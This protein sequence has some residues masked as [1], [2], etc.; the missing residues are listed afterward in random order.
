M[1][2]EYSTEVSREVSVSPDEH[3]AQLQLLGKTGRTQGLTA[4]QCKDLVS[5]LEK[6]FIRVAP[7]YMPGSKDNWGEFRSGQNDMVRFLR[8]SVFG[9]KLEEL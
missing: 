7:T 8:D 2:E 1:S 9:F 6:R 3:M 5:L 4:A